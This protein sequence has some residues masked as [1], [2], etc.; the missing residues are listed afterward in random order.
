M[1]HIFLATG[2][3]RPRPRVIVCVMRPYLYVALSL[4]LVAGCR[5]AEKTSPWTEPVLAV[6]T[7][8]ALTKDAA[9]QVSRRESKSPP[10]DQLIQQT[11]LFAL[12]FDRRQAFTLAELHYATGSTL[13]EQHAERCVDHFYQAAGFAY[14][15]LFGV[16]GAA[17]HAS[18]DERMRQI[19]NSSLARLIKD[20]QT[21]GRLDPKK[22]LVVMAADGR[23][24]IP[25][26]QQK[27]PWLLDD[28]DEL[29]VVGDYEPLDFHKRYGQPGLG[30]ALV[31]VRN[32]RGDGS[33]RD[34]F[35]FEKHPFAVSVVLRPDLESLIGK[36]AV[37]TASLEDRQRA[38][39]ELV[40]PLRTDGVEVG[41]TRLALA[42]DLS[43]P[44]QYCMDSSRQFQLDL[45][46]FRHPG[47][48][49]KTAGLYFIEPYQRGKIP[50]VFVHGLLSDPDTWDEMLNELRADP[51]LSERFQF[52]V[53]MYPTG[54]P[55]LL[56]AASL[57]PEA[58]GVA[59]IKRSPPPRSGTRR[60]R[61]CRP[62]HG[63]RASTFPGDS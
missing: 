36:Q 17:G 15:S 37:A 6:P 14:F 33:P 50:V 25:L 12:Q 21:Y 57:A 31:A 42:C 62:Q 44:L 32:R 5:S 52:A 60:D 56:S 7:L 45:I 54:N 41:G 63:R 3:D 28:N 43:A 10:A 22:Q 19:Y 18:T 48:P 34:R 4:F 23:R 8:T 20:G 58:Q 30:V 49:A 35:L 61:A 53:Y 16:D 40:D 2:I 47:N 9:D 11:R 51:D 46:G 39:L 29:L 38:R 55:F 27:G 13:A 26:I 59:A 24:V 1:L